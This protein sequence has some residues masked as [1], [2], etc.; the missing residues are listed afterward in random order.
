MPFVQFR[1]NGSASSS[2]WSTVSTALYLVC[3][4]CGAMRAFAE[5]SAGGGLVLGAS[6]C[7]LLRTPLRTK[8][9]RQRPSAVSFAGGYTTFSTGCAHLQQEG[10][11]VLHGGPVGRLGDV[12]TSRPRSVGRNRSVGPFGLSERHGRPSPV[13]FLRS[14]MLGPDVTFARLPIRCGPTRGAD[15]PHDAPISVPLALAL[16]SLRRLWQ[17]TCSVH[18]PWAPANPRSRSCPAACRTFICPKAGSTM[19]L[20]LA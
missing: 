18:S 9:K 19:A 13:V 12:A 16:A 14:S 11:A 6:H 7:G 3:M 4:A 20:R 1:M 5:R 8:E 10:A 15:G 2:S 17:M